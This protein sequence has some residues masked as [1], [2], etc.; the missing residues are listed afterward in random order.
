MK[1]IEDEFLTLEEADRI[2]Q[3]LIFRSNIERRKLILQLLD[4]IESI[5]VDPDPEFMKKRS[6]LVV[7]L[8]WDY[9]LSIAQVS[10]FTGLGEERI[11]EILNS[12]KAME[13]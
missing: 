1:K 4:L 2:F 10:R 12:R 5:V 8:V 11:Q 9:G 3:R 13:T 6:H 7:N